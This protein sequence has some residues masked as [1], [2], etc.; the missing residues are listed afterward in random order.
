M[1]IEIITGQSLSILGKDDPN[2]KAFSDIFFRVTKQG[3]NMETF[4]YH[5]CITFILL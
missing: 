2:Y 1:E 3:A 4:L 5:F